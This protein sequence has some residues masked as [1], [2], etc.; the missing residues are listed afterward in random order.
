MLLQ[1]NLEKTVL[2]IY[3][4]AT[5]EEY[6]D[7]DINDNKYDNID[8]DSE[9]DS[10]EPKT[11]TV[12]SMYKIMPK[13]KDLVL[14]YIGHTSNF[15]QRCSSH[16]KNTTN[17][18]DLRHYNL[19]LYQTIRNNGGWDSWQMIEIEKYVCSTIMEARMREQQLMNEHG[20]NLNTCKAYITEDE[21]KKRKQEI[22]NKYKEEHKEL[23]K[24]QTKKYKE[25]HKHVI[26]EQM[27]Q[28]RQEHKAEL[29]EKKK[30]YL[31]ANAE[32][33]KENNKIWREANKEIL[34]EKRKIYNEKK[35]Q[36]LLEAQKEKGI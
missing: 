20:S 4:M 18:N 24:E 1:N 36:Q 26:K 33:F 6:S 2:I 16:K 29:Y 21:R 5:K 9:D 27:R 31:K 34:K 25:E 35:K 7:V 3:N 19:K 30:E 15:N 11:N 22:T 10:N 17:S 13:N 14:S 12:Y 32:K 28:Y 8:T 23:I